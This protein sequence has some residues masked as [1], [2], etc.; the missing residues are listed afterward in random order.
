MSMDSLN[1]III[2]ISKLKFANKKKLESLS[3]VYTA[4]QIQNVVRNT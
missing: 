1:Q 3:G 2:K 4:V